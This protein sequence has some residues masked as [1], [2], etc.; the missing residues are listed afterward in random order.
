MKTVENKLLITFGRYASTNNQQLGVFDIF[1][2]EANLC[3]KSKF[4]ASLRH[5]LTIKLP[6]SLG[7]DALLAL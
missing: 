5:F 3:H 2:G 7:G 1:R 4:R 6:K